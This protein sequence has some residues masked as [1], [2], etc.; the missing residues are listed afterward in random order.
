MLD[1]AKPPPTLGSRMYISLDPRYEANN[2]HCAWGT[3][4]E[5]NASKRD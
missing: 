3:E 5:K 1:N 4:P 2:L